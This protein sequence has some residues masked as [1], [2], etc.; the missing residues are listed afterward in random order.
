V[1]TDLLDT[2]RRLQILA[3]CCLRSCVDGTEQVDPVH[4]LDTLCSNLQAAHDGVDTELSI[5]LEAPRNLVW[6][7]HLVGLVEMAVNELVTNAVK[8][9]F[10]G[11]V[12]GRVWVRLTVDDDGFARLSVR[13]SGNGFAANGNR[14]DGVG[15]LLVRSCADQLRS[16]LTI[17]TVDGT[18]IGIVFPCPSPFD[19]G[20]GE[21]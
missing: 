10:A 16:Q 14:R 11:C 13:D 15:M 8:H 19:T 3:G 6:S 18:A 12:I 9:A 7:G 21:P 1:W 4:I 2:A 20:K 5:I 17:T